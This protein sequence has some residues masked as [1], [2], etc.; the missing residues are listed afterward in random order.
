MASQAAV[1]TFHVKARPDGLPVSNQKVRG[2]FCSIC[3]S[4]GKSFEEYTSHFVRESPDPNSRVVCPVILSSDCNYCGKKGHLKSHC[5]L[6]KKRNQKRASDCVTAKAHR[7]NRDR[8]SVHEVASFRVDSRNGKV[9]RQDR[10]WQ[11]KHSQSKEATNIGSSTSG[12]FAALGDDSD[13]E[14][15]S[16]Q[17]TQRMPS[18]GS[19]PLPA[20][21]PYGKMMKRVAAKP[22]PLV[23]RMEPK[24]V[25]PSE[26][27]PAAPK[28]AI[29]SP[30]KWASVVA[31]S[32]KADKA[33][34]FNFTDDFA[35]LDW[36][37]EAEDHQDDVT[38]ETPDWAMT[39][40][41]KAAKQKD[42]IAEL[43]AEIADAWDD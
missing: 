30:T 19:R 20:P 1:L 10:D 33:V 16:V 32:Q 8:M 21:L 2:K 41:E 27:K 39:A 18:M 3:K 4:A 24:T 42:S 28:S 43:Q 29:K 38:V 35:D 23:I 6:L 13:E 11:R 15:E 22:E 40:E 36:A 25:Q 26:P 31:P 17:Q 9:S 12:R 34:T 5:H 7:H 14:V 37:D